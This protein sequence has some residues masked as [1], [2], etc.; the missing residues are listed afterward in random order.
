M[1]LSA[2]CSWCTTCARREIEF[3]APHRAA[4]CGPKGAYALKRGEAAR[5]P[6]ERS[7]QRQAASCR[8][9][10][11]RNYFSAS[12]PRYRVWMPAIRRIAQ[13]MVEVLASWPRQAARLA[14][15]PLSGELTAV[16][17]Q[18]ASSPRQ[19]VLIPGGGPRLRAR[20]CC[21]PVALCCPAPSPRCGIRPVEDQ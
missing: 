17:G 21:F 4:A 8:E 12:K 16:R 13:L 6:R 7:A 18:F 10:P 5:R 2:P 14:I 1:P 9:L 15:C 11:C 19:G 20:Q 3:L